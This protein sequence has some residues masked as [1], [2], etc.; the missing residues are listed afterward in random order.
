MRFL[1]QT[2]VD[3]YDLTIDPNQTLA[4]VATPVTTGMSV[5]VTLISPSGKVIGTAT[6]PTPGAP[7]DLPGVQ[8]SKGGTYEI[9]ITGG[10]GEY[11]VEP[12][13]NAYVDPAAYGGPLN[14]SIATATPIDPYA[15]EFAGDDDRTA[16]LGSIA[17]P[18][19]GGLYSTDRYTQ[20]LYSV[21]P[22]TGA[23]TLI[24]PLTYT[25][26]FSGMA[27]DPSSGTTYISDLFDPST[28]HWSLGS[29]DL[30][31][32]A[33]TII[34]PQY[35]PVFNEYDSDIHAL[36]EDDGTLYAFSL[37]RGLGTMNP[38]NGE[39]TPLLDFD[40]MPE[41]IENAAIDPATGTVYGIGQLTADIY[42]INVS[43]ATA[44]FVG[45]SG[46]GFFDIM[47][48]AYTGGSLYS[49]G[50]QGLSPNNPL[51]QINPTTGIG[52]F[53]GPNGMEYEPD[54]MTSPPVTTS[55][56]GETSPTYSFSLNQGESASIAIQ[57]LNN[58]N[59]SF[60]LLDDN[61]DVVARVHPARP[62]TP[63][64][65]TTSS[66]PTTRR[67]TCRSQA[68]P[69][70]SS[71]WWSPAAPTSTPSPITNTRV[72]RTSRRPNFRATTSSAVCWVI[73]RLPTAPTITR[74]T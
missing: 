44:T 38:S 18:A 40:S 61:G 35:D 2:D 1:N 49:L 63:P 17:P 29:I 39:F 37:T 33:E 56:P 10:P 54:A 71:T 25:T 55:G 50:Y 26:S 8:S 11:T 48:L 60:V 69:G 41:P 9:V 30:T 28:E 68:T 74:S 7:V 70:L 27:V 6:S 36:V 53:I 51:Y 57:S 32:G 4:V 22:S 72:P 14:N 58:T 24:G 3:T 13:L 65:S 46:T 43:T 16:V 45:S 67:I 73:S 20:G 19:I 12:I 47:G 62:I 21:N 23:S 64:A 34:G 59:V 5:T 42:T 31:T 52:T 15:N 66:P